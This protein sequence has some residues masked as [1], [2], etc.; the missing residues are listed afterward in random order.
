MT[1]VD[2]LLFDEQQNAALLFQLKWQDP[3]GLD[4]KAKLSAARN[5]ERGANKWVE[6]TSRWLEIYGA[7]ELGVRT[8]MPLNSETRVLLLVMGR[9]TGPLLSADGLDQRASWSDWATF[10]QSISSDTVGNLDQ[11]CQDLKR[12]QQA[13]ADPVFDE[14]YSFPIGKLTVTFGMSQQNVEHVGPSIH[15]P[16][17]R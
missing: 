14:S 9:Y 2:F 8:N 10:L 17:R 13:V 11:L 7:E 1:D 12:R 4:D 3:V 6:A 16:S 5:F 15:L